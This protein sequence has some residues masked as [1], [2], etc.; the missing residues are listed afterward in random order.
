MEWISRRKKLQTEDLCEFRFNPG[1]PCLVQAIRIQ[2]DSLLAEDKIHTSEPAYLEWI[3]Q[4]PSCLDAPTVVL[5]M[6]QRLASDVKAT[7][8]PYRKETFRVACEQ[9]FQHRSVAYAIRRI[10]TATFTSRTTPPWEVETGMGSGL[11]NCKSDT[12]S[13][14]TGD[15]TVLSL[16]HF[17][18]KPMIFARQELTK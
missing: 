4:L 9:L 8:L 18:K 2:R 13:L 3:K 12:E 6:H 15:D 10:S 5:V 16:T 11:Y 17:P 7:S 14:A 1:C